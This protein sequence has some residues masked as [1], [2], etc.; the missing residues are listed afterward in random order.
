[1]IYECPDCHEKFQYEGSALIECPSCKKRVMVEGER[2]DGTPWDRAVGGKRLEAF[3][4]TIKRSLF[5]PV[6]FFRDVAN[7]KEWMMPVIFTL[8]ITFFVFIIVAAYKIG[9]GAFM[10]SVE[11]SNPGFFPQEFQAHFAGFPLWITIIGG[12]L[13][14]PVMT[15]IMLLIQSSLYHICLMITGGAKVGFIKTFRV[16]CYCAGPQVLQVVPFLGGFIA[17]AWQM[18]LAIIGLKEVHGTSYGKSVLAVF[19]PM[20]ICCGFG[21]LLFTVIMG[22]V[23][24]GAVSSG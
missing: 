20:L 22:A 1:M 15:T 2:A 19:L 3:L 24:A 12:A 6:K 9:F 14:L 8:I 23:F 16:T 17:T 18:T 4:D 10:L 7:S 5:E 11:N 13:A 21:F